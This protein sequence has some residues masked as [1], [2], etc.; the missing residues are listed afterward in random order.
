MNTNINKL[1]NRERM[2]ELCEIAGSYEDAAELIR[3]HTMRPCSRETI[4]SWTCDPE[5]TRAR[6]CHDWAILALETRLRYLGKI[7]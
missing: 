1:K 2:R 4:K 3:E 6:T 7:A 5:I